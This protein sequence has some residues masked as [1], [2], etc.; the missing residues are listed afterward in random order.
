[1]LRLIW[2]LVLLVLAATLFS[3]GH[4]F[5]AAGLLVLAIATEVGFRTRVPWYAQSQ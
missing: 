1:M 2:T 3:T 5:S 4:L